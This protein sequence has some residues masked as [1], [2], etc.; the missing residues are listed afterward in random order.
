MSVADLAEKAQASEGSVIQ[1]C[2]HIGFK[3]FQDLKIALAKEVGG[4]RALVHEDIDPADGVSEVV[5]KIIAGHVR[6]LEDTR[7]VMD[8]GAVSA[9]V[10]AFIKARRIEVYGIG[11][12]APIAEGAAYRLRRLGLPAFALTD[13]HGQAVSAAFAGGDAAVLTISHS[14]RTIETLSAT[15]LAKEAGARTIVITNYGRSPLIEHADIVLHTA[16][17]EARYG[18]E[19]MSS[20]IAQ[21]AV[22]DILYAAVALKRWA[23]SLEAID[24]AHT[25]IAAKRI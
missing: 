9:A 25:V 10:T 16:A 8:P 17:R 12:S 5:T 1:L 13:S 23:P 19:A 2:Q 7:K 24:I 14:G 20:R 22:I 3:G 6:A 15:R 21:L 11:T 18:M 4:A